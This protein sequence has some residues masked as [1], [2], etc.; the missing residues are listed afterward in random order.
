MG[1]QQCEVPLPPQRATSTQ[2]QHQQW[3][4]VKPSP[5]YSHNHTH[6]PGAMSP[7]ATWQPN[8]EQQPIGCSSSSDWH[9]AK[10]GRW[11]Q[12]TTSPDTDDATTTWE[13]D[14]DN[15]G[16]LTF[17]WISWNHCPWE[18]GGLGMAAS[19]MQG[20]CWIAPGY[21]W[22]PIYVFFIICI[23]ADPSL[24]PFY[25]FYFSVCRGVE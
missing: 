25:P 16:S 4:Q 23:L 20:R 14:D 1:G 7:I 11:W 5:S 8:D 17:W 6:S 24:L 2:N 15:D 9:N 19:G 18:P 13:W 21:I 3:R 12:E 22:E 10:P